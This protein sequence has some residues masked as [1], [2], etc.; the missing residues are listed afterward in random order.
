[1]G[2]EQFVPDRNSGIPHLIDKGMVRDSLNKMK[3][4]KAAA[5][6]GVVSEMAKAAGETGVDMS[7]DIVNQ[8]LVEGV[9]PAEWELCTIV[10][11]YKGG[12][13]LQK[14]ETTGE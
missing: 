4:G 3:N 5:P 2:W 12:A 8:L 10:N 14:E 7:T 13:I 9:I 1:M 11:F 6:P